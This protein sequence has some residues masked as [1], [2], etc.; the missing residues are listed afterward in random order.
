M[1]NPPENVDPVAMCWAF[2]G[3]P[4]CTS[5]LPERDIMLEAERYR[6]PGL[7]PAS[8]LTAGYLAELPSGEL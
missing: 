5:A 2:G 1:G 4:S 8:I 7:R 3:V 6:S